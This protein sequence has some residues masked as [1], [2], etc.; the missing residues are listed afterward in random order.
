[1]NSN[2]K[3]S[4]KKLR[5]IQVILIK[6]KQFL[7]WFIWQTIGPA[8]FARL[9]RFLWMQSRMD[10][11]NNMEINGEEL[12]QK[13]I[14]KF[15]NKKESLTVF[16]VGANVGL[17]SDKFVRNLQ[18]ENFKLNKLRV[19]LFEPEPH[20]NH[21]L[22]EKFSDLIDSKTLRINQQGV[23]DKN[24]TLSFNVVAKKAGTNSL[25]IFSNEAVEKVIDVQCV[26]IDRYTFENNIKYID[27]MKVDTEGNDYNVLLGAKKLFQQKKVGLI[28]FEYNFR[29]IIFRHFLRDVFE[30]VL[31][32]DYLIGK[33]TPKGII[34]F[35]EWHPELETFR[36]NNYLIW[37]G[38]LIEKIGL[39]SMDWWVKD[40]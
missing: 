33:I 13:G 24:S 31:P 14:I 10:G 23:T 7:S 9:G 30:L 18:K 16:D 6:L 19:H 37:H 11:V 26:S 2:T 1:M 38:D 3:E 27:F 34:K 15:Y 20:A 29:W 36:E 40:V 8:N 21:E 12:V 17:W 4:F 32:L 28:Q 39:N 35:D 22:R 25:Q 5:W